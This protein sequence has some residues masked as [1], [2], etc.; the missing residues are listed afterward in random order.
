MGRKITDEIIE[1]INELYL[2]IGVKS[3]VAKELGI[4][5]STVSKYIQEGYIGKAERTVSKFDKEPIL[6]TEE[7]IKTIPNFKEFLTNLTSEEKVQLKE[8]Q[9]KEIYL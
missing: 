7:K 9:E 3:R 8:L 6:L 5:A 1:Q 4:S 2:K